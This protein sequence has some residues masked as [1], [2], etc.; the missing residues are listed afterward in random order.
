MLWFTSNSSSTGAT[1]STDSNS[2]FDSDSG[3]TSCSVDP[4]SSEIDYSPDD[5]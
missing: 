4:L 5:E 3:L 2:N 1:S